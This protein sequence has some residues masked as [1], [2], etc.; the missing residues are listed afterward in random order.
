MTLRKKGT[1]VI[2]IDGIQYRWIVAPNDEPGL[3]IVVEGAN[4]PGRRLVSWVEHGT[5][6]TPALIR[7]IILSGRR[8]GW[9]PDERGTDFIRRHPP[10]SLGAA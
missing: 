4:S 1:R 6:I 10:G 2:A 3:A 5:L 7:Q 8:A 9:L